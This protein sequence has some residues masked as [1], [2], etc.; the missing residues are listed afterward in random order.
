MR[1]PRRQK[2]ILIIT[3]GFGGFV[4]I[5]DV[6]RIAYLQQAAMNRLR[7]IQRHASSGGSSR[8]SAENDFSWY[9]S[10]S[11][12]WSAV[13]VQTGI[14]IANVPGMKSLVSRFMPRILRDAGE[15][16]GT[17]NALN[18]TDMET[19]QSLP[20][21]PSDSP[22]KRPSPAAGGGWDGP[23]DMMDFLTTPEMNEL[24]CQRMQTVATGNTKRTSSAP[25]FFDFVNFKR[26]KSM[27]KMTNK[28]SFFPVA[29][30]TVLFFIWGFAYGLLDVLNSQFQ[31]IAQMSIPESIG[32]HSA[33]FAGYLIGP[34]TFGRLILKHWGFKACFMV[35]L[36]IYGCAVLLFWPA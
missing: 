7:D 22:L 14:I 27:V 15:S 11:F 35:G 3:F 24:P 33:Y 31:T 6:V 12:M 17:G 30:V 4:A 36:V 10:Y 25:T 21:V 34:L 28:E 8:N 23:V 16:E 29:M 1:L 5:V 13:E 32:I 20:S 9:A 26:R 18:T 2:V 19:A